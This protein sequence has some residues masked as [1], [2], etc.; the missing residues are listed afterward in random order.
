MLL[1]WGGMLGLKSVAGVEGYGRNVDPNVLTLGR[2]E[3]GR[4]EDG[5]G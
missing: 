4:G 2:R 1:G 5:S 3:R